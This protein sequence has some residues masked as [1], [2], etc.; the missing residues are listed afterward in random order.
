MANRAVVGVAPGEPGRLFLRCHECKSIVPAWQ[1]MKLS[2]DGLTGCKCGCSYVRPA[3]VPNV[4]AAWWV[5]VRGIV[6]R[7]WIQKKHDWDPR[8]PHRQ[9]AH[10]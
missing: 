9:V 7:K 1:V 3:N 5:L 6:I 4:L 10:G 8:I 2:K